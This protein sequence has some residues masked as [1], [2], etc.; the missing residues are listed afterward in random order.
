MVLKICQSIQIS[1]LAE[2]NLYV[3]QVGKLVENEL[4]ATLVVFSYA[5]I[6]NIFKYTHRNFWHVLVQFIKMP[7]GAG[8]GHN[9]QTFT[10]KFRRR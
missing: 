10:H 4:F 3:K 2:S 7:S 1:A 6:E 8:G 5:G 9:I